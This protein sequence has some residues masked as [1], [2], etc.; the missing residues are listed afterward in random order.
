MRYNVR[1]DGALTRKNDYQVFDDDKRAVSLMAALN[2]RMQQDDPTIGI[3]YFVESFDYD[4]GNGVENI[5]TGQEVKKG[6]PF[7]TLKQ[8]GGFSKC[9]KVKGHP[10]PWLR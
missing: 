3:L 4:I 7:Q 8:R 1:F 2:Y 6:K 10:I 9:N 5:D